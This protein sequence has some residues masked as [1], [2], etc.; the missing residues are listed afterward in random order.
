MR[1]GTEILRHLLN[2]TKRSLLLF[3]QMN[4][5]NLAPL[6][7]RKPD[8]V[9][10]CSLFVFLIF[11]VTAGGCGTVG[12]AHQKFTEKQHS[13]TITWEPSVS[14]VVGYNVYRADASGNNFTKLTSQPVFATK[15]TDLTVEAGKTYTYYVSAVSLNGVESKPSAN[16]TAKVPSP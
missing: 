6:T 10:F 13:V 15:Y 2:L 11:A 7:R 16:V 8:E 9:T 1:P 5:S 4:T 12:G 3:P 14:R